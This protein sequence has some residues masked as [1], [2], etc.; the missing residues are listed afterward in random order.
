MKRASRTI[1]LI[2]SIFALC[3]MAKDSSCDLLDKV[4][5]IQ[6]SHFSSEVKF[7]FETKQA[8]LLDKKQYYKIFDDEMI[9]TDSIYLFGKFIINK[10][11][12]GVYS[13]RTT[14]ECD[15]RIS[16]VE[17]QIFDNCKKIG[18][19][20]ILFEDNHVFMYNISSKFSENFDNLEII[21]RKNSEYVYEP[22][23]EKDT[24]F[25][26][27][28]KIDLKSKNLDTISKKSN[29]EILKSPPQK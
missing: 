15:H 18:S 21:E 8:I 17:L 7:G 23:V 16:M 22:G 13:Y 9:E 5:L 1:F 2:I 28:Y 11:R 19:H 10:N 14:S 4:K 12:I 6:I 27:T 3:A 24:L 25:T 26:N 29:Y 20:V